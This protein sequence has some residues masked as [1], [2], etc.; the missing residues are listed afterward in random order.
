[1][2][3]AYLPLMLLETVFL[4]RTLIGKCDL[5]VGLEWQDIEHVHEIE[6]AFTPEARDGRRF[7][8]EST[9]MTGILRGD[10][11][12]DRVQV[13]EMGP[14]GLICI[15]QP[16]IAR[17]EQV[18]I[19]IELNED[20][21]RFRARGVWLREEGDEYRVGLQFIGMP[22]KLHKVQISTHTPDVVDKISAA[23]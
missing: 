6:H 2:P 21:Y 1:M 14:G 11:I 12:N 5:G 15:G 3:P 16:F 23:A 10:Q 4:Y 13:V 7:R 17:G 22:V 8:R 18:E 19:V 9:R 20:I